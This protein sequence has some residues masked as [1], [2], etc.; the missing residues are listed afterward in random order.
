MSRP[1]AAV[2]TDS[3]QRQIY[4]LLRSFE[5]CDTQCL[6]RY[7]VTAAQGTALLAFPEESSV[8][9]NEL[10]QTMG[11]ANSTMT[12][13][14]DQLV[15]KGLA[16]RRQGD[17]DRRVVRVALTAQGQGLQRTLEEARRELLRRILGD[18]KEGEWPTVLHSL[19]KLNGAVEK[20]M[21]GFCG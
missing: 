5:S 12:R 2:F 7:G 8:S 17:E 14:V 21:K 9:M 16:R 1:E 13:M 11:L 20:V 19:E 4:K 3:M 18:I 6:A 10:S 15:A